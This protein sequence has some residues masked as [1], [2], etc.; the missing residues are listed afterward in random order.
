MRSAQAV[1]EQ[2]RNARLI[3][4]PVFIDVGFPIAANLADEKIAAFIWMIEPEALENRFGDFVVNVKRLHLVHR[5]TVRNMADR[6][7]SRTVRIDAAMRRRDG[8][9]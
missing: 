6:F 9:Q 3:A 4:T 1:T 7:D 5:V 2:I 8:Q